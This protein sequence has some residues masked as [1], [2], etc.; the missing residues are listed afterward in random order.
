MPD[1]G[2]MVGKNYGDF[3]LIA[4]EKANGLID[5]YKYRSSKTGLTTVIA[6]VEGPVVNGYFVLGYFYFIFSIFS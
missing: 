2:K 3:Q 6:Q 1:C 5:V 4:H